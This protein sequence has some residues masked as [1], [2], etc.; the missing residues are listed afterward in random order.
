[1]AFIPGFAGDLSRARDCLRGARVHAGH[2]ITAGVQSWLSA[3]ESEVCARGG[4]VQAGLTAVLHAEELYE[5]RTDDDV[6][7][8]FDWFS[9][10]HLASFA[11][12]AHLRAGDLPRA[13]E[14]LA[15]ALP[16]LPSG[17][18]QRAILLADMASVEIDGREIEEACR[19]LADALSD[20]AVTG[21]ATG[22]ER[23]REVR[24]RLDGCRDEPAVRNLDEILYGSRGGSL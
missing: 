5:G 6:P 14:K 15:S 21:Y 1:M 8:W 22:F 20:L 24:A 18:K 11:G 17:T 4:D 9:P 10:Q 12:Y 7:Q 13:R 2:G 23:V 16:A 3:A 19:L